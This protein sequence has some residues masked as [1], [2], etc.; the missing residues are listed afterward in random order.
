[1]KVVPLHDQVLLELIIVKEDS[2]SGD[3]LLAGSKEV[4]TGLCQVLA[5][6]P[7]VPSKENSKEMLKT[8]PNYPFVKV[9][10]NVIAQEGVG[11][12]LNFDGRKYLLTKSHNILA[13]IEEG[14]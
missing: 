9:G 11:S 3:I 10:D 2:K 5:V 7:D 14:E 13:I 4:D 12:E 6:G 1:M 8:R